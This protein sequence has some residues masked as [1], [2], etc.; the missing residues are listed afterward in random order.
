MSL[1]KDMSAFR[2]VSLASIGA[3]LY[4]GIVLII[5]LPSYY[6]Q[7]SVG[8]QNEPAYWDLNI[9]KGCSMT[10]FAYT[11]QIQMLPIYSEMVNPNYKRIKKVI[12]RSIAIDFCFYLTIALAGYFS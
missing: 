11:C 3:L 1:L 8:A 2:H 7:F 4:T 12:Q 5:E 6:D 10:F 9:F